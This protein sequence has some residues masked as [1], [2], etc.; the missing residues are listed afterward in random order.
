[1]ENDQLEPPKAT[2]GDRV[3]SIVKAGL[4]SIPG[5]GSVAVELF[6]ALINQPLEKRRD[7]WMAQVGE[8]LQELAEQ[9]RINLEEL[10]KNDA[11]IDLLMNAS[12]AAIRNSHK[13][14]KAALLNAVMN[15]ALNQS[16]DESLQQTFIRWIDGLTV[17][18]LRLLSL[19][20]S[21]TEWAKKHKK[22]FARHVTHSLKLILEEAYP[23][24]K[25]ENMLIEIVWRDLYQQGLINT[26]KLNAMMTGGGLS[27]RRTTDAGNEFLLFIERVD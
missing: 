14:K 12:Q 16:P 27:Q 13:E 26:D 18:H 22:Q 23:E 15:A 11:F 3:H 7:E 6:T 2:S 4:G 21:P 5:V 1:M 24:L 19:F 25:K 10:Q 8:R 20:Q 17:W 9:D